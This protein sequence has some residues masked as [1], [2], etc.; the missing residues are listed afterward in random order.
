MGCGKTQ[1]KGGKGGETPKS[2]E[3]KTSQEASKS[4]CGS[5]GKQ[6]PTS[7]KK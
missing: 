4:S 3:K 6:R 7:P 2:G 1:E 5:S